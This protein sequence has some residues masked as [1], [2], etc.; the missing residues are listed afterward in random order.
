MFELGKLRNGDV[1]AQSGM[2]ATTNQRIT[3]IEQM[4]RPQ[5]RRRGS[6]RH[7]RKIHRSARH[8]RFQFR[9]IEVAHRHAHT[10]RP[11]PE[12]DGQG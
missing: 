2:I 5:A 8:L 6:W 10:G 9:D 12:R 1:F 7:E 11:R 4:P 3:F